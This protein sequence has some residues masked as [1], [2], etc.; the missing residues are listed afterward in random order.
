[1]N[2]LPSRAWIRK[3][4]EI[5]LRQFRVFIFQRLPI[6]IPQ[7]SMQL[8]LEAASMHRQTWVHGHYKW[9]SF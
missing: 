4:S 8:P 9:L 6:V 3:C 7:D 5:G 1:M 2:L